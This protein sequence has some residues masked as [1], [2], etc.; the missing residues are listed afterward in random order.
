MVEF[1]DIRTD[2]AGIVV[3]PKMLA[4]LPLAEVAHDDMR[5]E[6]VRLRQKGYV[7]AED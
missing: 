5:A 2:A 1:K 4:G 3:E 7:P 6:W